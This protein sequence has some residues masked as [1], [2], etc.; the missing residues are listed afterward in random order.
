MLFHQDQSQACCHFRQ[1]AHVLTSID[2]FVNHFLSV[3]NYRYS[4]IYGPTLTDQYVQWW[5]GRAVG[6]RLSPEFTCLL[7]RICAYSVQYL[8]PALRKMIE[9]ELACD[10]QAL[11]DRFASAAEELSASFS[12]SNTT[13]E[14]VQEQFLK[15]AWLKSESKIVESWHALGCTIREAQ[16]LGIDK[17]AGIESLSEFDIEIRRRIWTLLYIWDWQ[18]SAWLGRPN[19]IDQKNLTFKFPNLR[20][21]QSSN[22]PNL[23]SPFAHMALQ[24]NLGRR[25]ATVLGEA[26]STSN[27]SAKAVIAV[28]TECEKFIEELP[29]IFRVDDIDTS[30]DREHPYF[31]FQR[32]QMHCVIFVTMLDFL[33]PYLTRDRKDKLTEYDDDFRNKGIKIALRLL[34][35]ARKL[36]DHEFPINAKFH[37]VV[38]SIFDTATLLCSAII[39]DR[40]RVLPHREEVME[41]IDASLGMLHQLSLATKLG[42]SSY[43]FLYK[44]VQAT[45]ELARHSPNKKRQKKATAAVSNSDME[46]SRDLPPPTIAPVDPAL[47]FTT[48]ASERLPATN[49]ADDLAFDVENFLA[50]NPFGN[51]GDTANLDMGGMEQ[52]WDWE[53]LH[54]DGFSQAGSTV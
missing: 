24:A 36:F 20:L 40:G 34:R 3:V 21:D 13:I 8:T 32:H 47:T 31:V 18:M 41:V 22:E 7:L 5:T 2:A 51:F 49:T 10:S 12:A 30:L 16:E 4:A 53:N 23:L 50:N 45:P 6:R 52:I 25:V 37:M 1:P 17:D 44:L 14:R 19:L 11:T 38:F 43:D 29:P 35:V 42:A 28:E 33:K 9:F 48:S 46:T 39:H 26:Q 54:L 15:G 27:L